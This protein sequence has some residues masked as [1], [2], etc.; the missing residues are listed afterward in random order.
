MASRKLNVI[1][2]ALKSH[3][4]KCTARSHEQG[5]CKVH[6][7]SR[8]HHGPHTFESN[9]LKIKQ[10]HELETLEEE[11]VVAYRNL[12]DTLGVVAGGNPA[13]D[14]LLQDFVLRKQIIRGK[15]AE[16][17]RAMKQRHELNIKNT[18]VDPDVDAKERKRIKREETEHRRRERE[19]RRRQREE[20]ADRAQ[21][22]V[23]VVQNL[24]ALDRHYQDWYGAAAQA[25]VQAPQER[26]LRQFVE[27]PQNIHTSEAVEQTKKIIEKVRTVAV[28]D[29]YRWNKDVCSKTPGEIIAECRLSQ[30]GAWQMMSQYAQD[31]AIYDIEEG[32]YGKVLD[33]VW[34]FVK[35]HAEKDSLV[36]ILR[37]ELHDNIGMCA[38]GN[39]TRICNILAGYMDG[40]SVA[41]SLA[42]KLGRLLPALRDVED[43]EERM[44]EA[45]RIL[46][47]NNVP[48]EERAVWIDAI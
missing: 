43:E 7:N 11:R 45:N 10:K 15:H 21:D 28:P 16:E 32:I 2:S 22:R 29:E 46:D 24:D 26:N 31:T 9:Q 41:E 44:R 18:G 47:E 12:M 35:T 14:A 38:Q 17:T 3:G 23:W 48:A 13:V 39:L 30:K 42:E 36:A 27:D 40:V 33:S 5:L 25:Q 8:L 20:E 4:D 37:T 6:L 34:Q 19:E 1:C